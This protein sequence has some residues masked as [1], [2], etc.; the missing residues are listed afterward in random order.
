MPP[1]ARTLAWLAGTI[2]LGLASRAW[3]VLGQMPGDVL[4]ATM[5]YFGCRLFAPRWSP[6]HAASVALAFCFAVELSQLSHLPALVALRATPLGGLVLG[7]GFLASDLALYA[8]GV[9]LGAALDRLG[10]GQGWRA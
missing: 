4:Y 9:V 2:A 3:P 5:A 7:H 8:L 1:A 6:R 10:R